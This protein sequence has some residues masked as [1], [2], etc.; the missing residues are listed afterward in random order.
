MTLRPVA[1][2]KSILFE[3][4]KPI[5]EPMGK[6]I[7]LGRNLSGH[8]NKQRGPEDHKRQKSFQARKRGAARPNQAQGC[9][10]NQTPPD[11][12]ER[13]R[14]KDTNDRQRSGRDCPTGQHRNSRELPGAAGY[15]ADSGKDQGH[16]P[17]GPKADPLTGFR[18]KH[19]ESL[20]IGSHA[21][22]PGSLIAHAGSTDPYGHMFSLLKTRSGIYRMMSM[23]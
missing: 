18:Q 9:N 17:R 16:T 14:G 11:Q 19:S 4:I 15:R 3:D 20:Q 13:K 7:D 21:S 12:R 10:A 22:L 1:P 23:I 8:N 2:Q 6:T 5:W